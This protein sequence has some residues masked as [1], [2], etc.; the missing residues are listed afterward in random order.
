MTGGTR[1]VEFGRGGRRI[2]SETDTERA[3]YDGGAH[4][5]S[6]APRSGIGRTI[7]DQDRFLRAYAA[8]QGGG[9]PASA[10]ER[11]SPLVKRRI[12]HIPSGS[13]VGVGWAQLPRLGGSL[14]ALGIFTE[15]DRFSQVALAD[16][17][18]R[19]F[20]APP[21]VTDAAGL[22]VDLAFLPERTGAAP[23]D[24]GAMPSGAGTRSD[25][26]LDRHRG[27]NGKGDSDGGGGGRRGGRPAHAVTGFAG[28]LVRDARRLAGRAAREMGR[29][30][31]RAGA[32]GDGGIRP[33]GMASNPLAGP[34][35]PV[36]QDAVVHGAIVSGLDTAEGDPAGSRPG[37]RR[38]P[39][40]PARDEDAA[41]CGAA[42]GL[43]YR[44]A[45]AVGFFAAAYLPLVAGH[46]QGYEFRG[47]LPSSARAG[48]HG[49]HPQHHR[50]DHR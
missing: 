29:G 26:D 44:D 11:L 9:D 27:R 4:S 46:P 32:G 14:I 50:L 3:L 42:L 19:V 5:G 30:L 34:A 33:I 21:T 31:R 12:F 16:W 43:S 10:S 1:H 20:L 17:H 23:A 36:P 38:G 2:M 47:G 24:G 35:R 15:E 37:S 28:R 8:G 49:R 40:R 39:L 7:I 45:V 41:S 48:A 22:K 13:Q 6:G 25:R 18:G